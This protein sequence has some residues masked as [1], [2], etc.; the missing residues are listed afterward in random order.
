MRLPSLVLCLA[1]VLGVAACGGPPERTPLPEVATFSIVAFDPETGDVG[2]ASQSKAFGVG[3]IVP[4]ARADI[5][6]IATQALAEPTYGSDGLA[7]LDDGL[8]AV[9]VVERLVRGDP[10]RDRRQLAVVDRLGRVEAFTGKGCHPWAGHVLGT[11]YACLGN[12]LAGEAVVKAMAAAYEKTP[13]KLAERLVAALAA[14]Q[15]AGGDTRGRRSASIMVARRFGGYR[16]RNDRY[17]DLRV[18]DHATPIAELA[19]VLAAR[20]GFLPEPAVPRRME[21][22]VREARIGTSLRPSAR[23]VWIR[24]KALH[25]EGDWKGIRAMCAHGWSLEG[26]PD[27]SLAALEKAERDPKSPQALARRGVYLGTAHADGRAKLHFDVRGQK[28]PVMVLMVREKDG[29]KIVP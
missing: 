17:I 23:E 26:G 18:E 8:P 29:W 6:A 4:H 21:G 20:R 22:L 7:M 24:W 25:A 10:G 1:G 15:A 14:G 27:D 11:H 5:G 16:G 28:Q 9:V 2:V 3:S 19:R 13:G 12:I